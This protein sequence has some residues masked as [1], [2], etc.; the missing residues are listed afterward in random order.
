MIFF[1]TYVLF[2]TFMTWF[3]CVRGEG[4]VAEINIFFPWERLQ[5]KLGGR[6]R[7]TYFLQPLLGVLGKRKSE[8]YLH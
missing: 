4:H 2:L 6:G 5:C 8:H 1:F 7:A 3:A